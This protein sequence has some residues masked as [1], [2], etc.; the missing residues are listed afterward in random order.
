MPIITDGTVN[1]DPNNQRLG[2]G[3]SYAQ[4]AT[5]GTLTL[6]G[7]ATTWNDYMMPLTNGKRGVTDLPDFDY[8]N[9]GFLFPRNDATEIIYFIGQ[10]PHDWREGSP[11]Y[12]HLHWSQNGG[13][14]IGW[15]IDYK[16]YNNG[17]TAPSAFTTLGLSSSIF[18]FTASPFIQITKSPTAIDMTGLTIS[19]I[20]EIKLYRNDNT[21]NGDALAKQFDIHYEIDGLGSRQEYDK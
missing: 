1:R 14:A 20:I 17:A 19:A 6:A 11:V 12:P 18:N 16:V 9:L 7:S 15:S 21:Y 2:T 13:S 4:F 10:M 8:T 5:D 3:D